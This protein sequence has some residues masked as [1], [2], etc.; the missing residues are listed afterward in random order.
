MTAQPLRLGGTTFDTLIGHTG[1]VGSNLAREHGFAHQFNSRNSGD[2]RGLDAQGVICAGVHAEKW[3]SNAEPAQDL[4]NIEDVFANIREIQT[5]NFILIS[6]VDVYDPPVACDESHQPD[7]AASHPYGRHRLLL[8]G[9]VL[10]HFPKAKII[11]LP[12]LF[13]SGLKKNIIFDLINQRRGEWI[14]PNSHLQWFDIRRLVPVLE[15]MFAND[16][17]L[18]NVVTEPV[19][20]IAL[21]DIIAPGYPIAEPNPQAPR[22][23]VRSRH[24]A[25]FGGRDGYL[26]DGAS[27]LADLRDFLVA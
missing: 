9:M 6:T 16:I 27:V 2:M 15:V 3:R 10:A 14:A 26:L 1:F 24:A 4:A 7:L 12:G 25:L 19:A 11:R 17:A 13:G 21:R 18:L 22:Y 5:D 20:T 23:D 8:E